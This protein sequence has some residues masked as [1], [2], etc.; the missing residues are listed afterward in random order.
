MKKKHILILSGIYVFILGWLPDPLL[1][2]DEGV[3]LA[4]F[5][6]TL[7][8]ILRERNARKKG[9]EPARGPIIEID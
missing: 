7:S 1:L 8:D 2:V 3:A 6:K 9:K 4:I 5:L